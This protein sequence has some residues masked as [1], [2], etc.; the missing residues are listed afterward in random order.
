MGNEWIRGTMKTWSAVRKKLK[1]SNSVSRA[2]KIAKNP[3]FIP[4]TI[5]SG[6]NKWANKGLIYIDQMFQG[7]TMKSFTQLQKEFNLPAHDFYKFLQLRDYLQKHQEWE[8]IYKTPSKLEEVLWSFSEDKSKKGVIS[9][10]Y[11]ALQHESDDNNLDIKEKWELEANIIISEEEWEETFKEGHK[12]TNSPTWREFDWKVKMRYFYTLFITSKYSNTTDL[13][14][15]ECGAVGDSTHIF[16]DCPK[17]QDFWKNI[18]KEIK[19]I[20]G[21]NFPLEPALYILGIIPDN[22]TD[23]NSK[24]LLR[25]LLLIAK[26]TIT[27]SWLKP[28]PP[29]ILQWRDGVKNVFI[30]E[31][32]TARLQLKTD[33][34][35]KRW[36]LLVKA[37]PEL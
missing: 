33:L 9:K 17:I 20:M 36:S 18:Q 15:R 29:S 1:M 3:D 12:L 35:D 14:W 4:S 5:D 22:M 7:Q 11:K 6:F 26:K 21:I 19:Q 24:Y 23:K 2:T 30:M 25:I 37:M 31:K 27:A 34:F 28:Q 16:W 32:I 13:C 10:I 8:N